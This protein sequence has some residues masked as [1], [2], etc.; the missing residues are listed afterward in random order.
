MSW[1]DPMKLTFV[2]DSSGSFPKTVTLPLYDYSGTYQVDWGDGTTNTNTA[3]HGFVSPGGTYLVEISVST[4]GSY[5]RWFGN[6]AATA[7]VGCT[8]LTNVTAWG[9]FNDLTSLMFA[10]YG[11]TNLTSVP[12]ASPPST[13]TDMY[14][15]FNGASNFNSDISRWDVGNVTNMTSM[16]YDATNFNSD[17]SRWDVGKVTTMA[18]MF[19][20][21]S[22]FNSDIS[23][24]NVGKV[25]TMISMFDGADFFNQDLS[26]WK[27]QSITSGSM[28]YMFNDAISYNV[29]NY[30]T[31]LIGWA[32]NLNTPSNITFYGGASYYNGLAYNAYNYLDSNGWTMQ[33]PS[34]TN[35]ILPVLDMS[36][37]MPTSRTY[38][39]YNSIIPY[40]PAYLGTYTTLDFSVNPVLPAG[41]ILDASN[42]EI[43]GIPTTAA[44]SSSYTITATTTVLTGSPVTLTQSLNFTILASDVYYSPSIY[45]FTKGTTISTITPTVA[46]G[47]TITSYAINNT[48]PTGLSFNTSNG[49][50]TGTP[51]T[52]IIPTTYIVTATKSD[53]SQ[54]TASLTFSVDMP[55]RAEPM[56]LV[57]NITTT[58]NIV[59]PLNDIAVG[60]NYKIDWGDS[61]PV[62]FDTSGYTFYNFATYTVNI[63][64]DTSG[65][66]GRFGLIY[67]SEFTG[68]GLP[69]GW[70]G[71]TKLT[72]VNEWGDFGGLTSLRFAF[73]ECSLLD[74][75]PRTLPSTVTDLFCTFASI[76]N[77][78][79]VIDISGWNVTNV[80][81]MTATFY[82]NQYFNNDL[83]LWNVENVTKMQYMFYGDVSFNRDLSR[84]DV[85][86]VTKMQHMFRNATL[87]NQDLSRW[88]VQKVTDMTQMFYSTALFNQDLSRWDLSGVT[89]MSNMFY[90]DPSFNALNYSVTLKG[91]RANSYTPS[92]I[93]F[94]GGDSIYNDAS[95]AY[96]YLDLDLSWNMQN[97]AS[98]KPVIVADPLLLTQYNAPTSRVYYTGEVIIPYSPVYT[99]YYT[100][101]DFSINQVLPTGLSLNTATGEI[102]GI[103]ST[104]VIDYFIVTTNASNPPFDLSYTQNINFTVLATDF[105]YSPSSYTYAWGDSSITITPVVAGGLDISSVTVSPALPTGLIL[106][107][108]TGI[109]SGKV[110]QALP[111]TIYTLTLTATDLSTHVTHLQMTVNDIS[112]NEPMILDFSGVSSIVLPLGNVIGKYKVDWGDGNVD[113]APPYHTYTS[114]GNYTVSIYTENPGGIIGTFGN[115]IFWLGYAYLTSV[116]A[117]GDFGGLTNLNLAFIGCSQLVA[118]PSTVPPTVTNM[119][120]MFGV[121]TSFNDDISTWDVSNVTNMSYMFYGATS[122]NQN[123]STWDV[124]EVTTMENMFS[125][126][127]SFNQDLSTWDVSEVTT[128]YYMF[129]GATSF[130][131]DLSTWDLS[132]VTTMENMFNGATDFNAL[133]YSAT[134][135]GWAANPQTPTSSITFWGGATIYNDASGAYVYLDTI[136]GWNMQNVP[137][138]IAT[139]VLATQYNPPTSRTYYTGQA[140]MPY[141]PLVIGTYNTLD[142][143]A[144]PVL[145]AG[146]FLNTYTGEI[147]GV[148]YAVGGPTTYTITATPYDLSGTALDASVIV[149]DLSFTILDSGFYYIPAVQQLTIDQEITPMGP[150]GSGIAVIVS[151]DDG[152]TLPNDLTIDVNTGI[153]SGDVFTPSEL[154]AYTITGNLS[155]GNTVTTTI[156]LSVEPAYKDPMILQF[157]AIAPNGS[158]GLPLNNTTGGYKVDWGDDTV[159]LNTLS[160]TYPRGGT[161]TV[162]IYADGVIG[163][164]GSFSNIWIGGA[165]LTAVTSWGDFG[166]LTR[167][168]NAFQDCTQLVAV[169]STIP[170]TVTDMESMFQG[171]TS[172]NGDLSQWDVSGVENMGGMFLFC[173][174]FNGDIS[175]WNVGQVTVMANMFSGA[176]SFN[177]D[178]S[179]WDVSQVINMSYMF[180]YATSFNGD[181]SSWNLSKVTDMNAMFSGATSFNGDL[182]KW[183]VR[184]VIYMYYMF[185]GATSFNG[186][187]SQW[188]VSQVT[189]MN[190]MF[191]GATSFNGD[192]SQWNVREVIYMIGMF[193]GA[194]SFNQNLGQWN[195]KHVMTMENMFEGADSFDALNYSATLIGWAA[196][197]ETPANITFWGGATLYEAAHAAYDYL[198]NDLNWNITPLISSFLATPVLVMQYNDPTSRIYY[199]GK[200]IGPYVPVVLGTY[201]HVIF[202]NSTAL[203]TGLNLN[204]ATGKITGI[205]LSVTAEAP[206][207]IT[208]TAYDATNVVIDSSSQTLTFT[209]LQ[210][211][212]YY[213]PP[214]YSFL[215]GIQIETISP[216]VAGGVTIINYSIDPALPPG[217]FFDTDDGNISGNS[218]NTSPT[219]TY[220]IIAT[221]D[222]NLELTCSITINVAN[223]SYQEPLNYDLLK[224]ISINAITPFIN[225]GTFTYA[226]TSGSLP[227]GITLNASSGDISGTP[228]ATTVL[229]L[230]CQIV[231]TIQD[232]RPDISYNTSQYVPSKFNF[233]FSVSDLSYTDLNYLF[234]KT[235]NISP[236]IPSIVANLDKLTLLSFNPS[237]P[238][239]LSF[240]NTTGQITGIPTLAIAATTYTLTI[241][242]NRN[243]QK[244]FPFNFAVADVSYAILAA[245]LFK[246]LPLTTI[247]PIISNGTFTY[248]LTSG[249]L[250]AGLTLNASS[251]DI[252]G[253]PTT[254]SA[255]LDLSCQV[256]ATIQDGR[257]D[258]S[259]NTDPFVF[260]FNVADLVYDLST[261][262]F[263]KNKPIY[264]IQPSAYANLNVLNL[265]FAPSLPLDLSLNLNNGDISGTP[266]VTSTGTAYT[267]TATT[268]VG[269]YQKQFPF[270][271]A[272]ADVSYAIL[273]ANLLKGVP[274]T[275]I[276]PTSIVPPFDTYTTDTSNTYI[277]D[278]NLVPIPYGATQLTITAVGG[279]GGNDSVAGT[280][281]GNG[282]RVISTYNLTT[283]N[284]SS[285]KIYI[286]GGGISN[287]NG[288]AG[289]GGFTQ[290]IS[291]D[292]NLNVVAGGGGG[293]GYIP[294]NGYGG[295]AGADASGGGGS[296]FGGDDGVYGGAGGAGG[297]GGAG[298]GG[299]GGYGFGGDGGGVGA[300]GETGDYVCGGGGGGAGIDASGG[301]AGGAGG[302]VGGGGG[303]IY[304]GGGGS[305]GGGGGGGYGG[306][307]GGSNVGGGG[308]GGSIALVNGVANTPTTYESYTGNYN[309]NNGFVILEWQITYTSSFR[310][311][312]TT[313]ALPTGLTLNTLT[314]DISGTPTT[315]T[316]VLDLSCQ[317]VATIPDGRPDLS[318]NTD[319]FEFTFNVSDLAYTNLTY[320]FFKDMTIDTIQPSAYANLNLLNLS[321]A[322]P[323]PLDLSLNL[324]NGDI[325]GTP[326]DTQAT[327]A[328]TLTATTNVGSYQKQFPFSFAIADI[329][330]DPID[331]SYV[332]LK[333]VAIE[334]IT[335]SA[336]A[337][338]AQITFSSPDI[339]PT[340]ISF[341]SSTGI[342]SGTPSSAQPAAAYTLTATT[343]SNYQKDFSFNFTVAAISYPTDGSYVFLTDVSINLI[344]PT[345]TSYGNF[346]IDNSGALP[347]GLTYGINNGEISGTPTAHEKNQRVD[348][349]AKI[350]DGR[351][352]ISYNIIFPFDFSVADIDYPDVSY[353]FLQ[354]QPYLFLPTD[355]SGQNIVPT[356]YDYA[357]FSEISLLTPL[358]PDLYF[359]L[360]T[361]II[362]GISNR[363]VNTANYTIQVTTNNGYSKAVVLNITIEGFNYDPSEYL[364]TYGTFNLINSPTLVGN[365]SIFT[366]VPDLPPNLSLDI[367]NGSISGIP[368]VLSQKVVY[369]VSATRNPTVT[370]EL[371]ISIC[372][373][374][375]PP[376][377]IPRVISTLNTRAMR[378]TSLVNTRT[379]RNGQLRIVANTNSNNATY[380][381]PIRNKF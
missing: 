41:L 9:D 4:N 225:N 92:N 316:A 54:V 61:N 32:A 57:F 152:G 251:G 13:V 24:W 76:T 165:Y 270:N 109:I 157:Q 71:N 369:Y 227:A 147:N 22:N 324:N 231:A 224:D 334:S 184:E 56:E 250:P 303:G 323:L 154:T 118:V 63:Y 145:P 21:A 108:S 355:L 230:S 200:S 328:H 45:I 65:T 319:P 182:S 376:V 149:Q 207:D 113:I 368:N 366:V 51:T 221:T 352:D 211:D 105:Y 137:T 129:N 106:A 342:I 220:E 194:T 101:L 136:K 114:P 167:L 272:V 299:A 181:I 74:F 247:S 171:A 8:F 264:T 43:S 195:L 313:G 10:F 1:R 134:L 372:S 81:D 159:N 126:A 348:I 102:S 268:N 340:D 26:R 88:D 94:W 93:T 75:V 14:G 344:T 190:F 28:N 216:I 196:N 258:I 82:N 296:G 292:F 77:N 189:N 169:P 164:F 123:L 15:M 84:W 66:I 212:L 133:N 289:G 111:E 243:Y 301:G 345:K 50:I 97:T 193:Y 27:L 161:Y 160:H 44:G 138:I 103:P 203:P 95:G 286:G 325:S 5:I 70:T 72:S 278:T 282:G 335:P 163:G 20:N 85:G 139:P 315:A 347:L 241:Y 55:W 47:V 30:S 318:Y 380:Q 143:S 381:M 234:L 261:C 39:T 179:A 173:T 162:K 232:G 302:S 49:Q 238:P 135:I 239:D 208:V 180:E 142:F 308:A 62:T 351:P 265:S 229:D 374:C 192:I 3:T 34:P 209:I 354:N 255:V 146:L 362:Q 288:G 166:N 377:I 321:F 58:K 353:V 371:I 262:V 287:N 236:I 283:L 267:L 290:V 130:N 132:G 298:G 40:S 330:Y 370:V 271:F 144:N 185:S 357:Y 158:I 253:T 213:D 327:T 107:S 116:I 294:A 304:G 38:Y 228:T 53:S 217:L 226:L 346:T 6:L 67:N 140:I 183:N 59:L 329:N 172:F 349:I 42:G 295:N 379:S 197:Y 310:Y 215:T 222:N 214:V 233:T 356:T 176:T 317:V 80:T 188:N 274:L 246:D 240:N 360:L 52:L 12:T 187:L 210:S 122:F 83:R 361:G 33:R 48:L 19:F 199:R 78:S 131:Q 331:A 312:L 242:T 326:T 333:T 31:T 235:V 279:R 141:V 249:T 373:F 90:G 259:Y 100:T 332:F 275:T 343:I 309:G 198:V 23:H 178:I 115:N 219:T 273:A 320:G 174:S 277:T 36:Y 79:N 73:S 121:A 11:C 18:N 110:I 124:S 91:W 314:G 156:V 375:P 306:G 254:A 256:V 364:L 128:M 117:W 151:Y 305:S 64:V 201:D 300:A 367:F 170:S 7:W 112:W 86:K 359:T 35:V 280:G 98:G 311:A 69:S 175:T 153:I 87:F 337:Y 297:V 307:G 252:S 338:L 25:T 206:Y 269:S 266:T 104:P 293:S 378:Y 281:G 237:L 248:A 68:S 204:T 336:A 186:D 2:I 285:V 245:D 168:S 127:T 125:G 257:P 150:S 16:F 322:P 341:N 46:G 218:N 29:L 350:Q 339:L 263:L 89:D 120:A 155:G 365:Y 17:I 205:P 223:I 177:G 291:N 96:N 202:S 244:Q 99:G 358:P 363:A 260:T 60:T 37:N 284:I 191:Q 119:S 276:S 148:P